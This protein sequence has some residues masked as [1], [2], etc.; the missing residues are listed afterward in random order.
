MKQTILVTGASSG[1][2]LLVVDRYEGRK[3]SVT[4]DGK[5]ETMPADG[6]GDGKGGARH[7]MMPEG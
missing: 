4:M 1:F 5:C 3:L 7:L 6:D 2:G